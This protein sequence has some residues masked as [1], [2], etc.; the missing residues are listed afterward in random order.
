MKTIPVTEAEIIGVIKSLKPTNSTQYDEISSK[1]LKLCGSLIS[2]PL[3]YICNKSISV[4][5]FPDR[6]KDATVK[7]LYKK[8]AKSSMNNY[9]PICLLTAISKVFVKIMYNRLNHY[10]QSHKI[11]AV[12]QY[13]FRKE[14]SIQHA[15]YRLTYIVLNA[16]NSKMHVGGIFC[17][18]A[19]AFDCV[20]HEI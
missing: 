3:C 14:L 8:G 4:G 7:P 11:L 6:L 12:E 18:L 5:I 15:T 19:K 1:I 10:L 17:D 2:R 9:R 13:G 20:N 16:W